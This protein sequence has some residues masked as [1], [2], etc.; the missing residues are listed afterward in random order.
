MQLGVPGDHYIVKTRA[1]WK[2]HYNEFTAT[3]ISTE[4]KGF[5]WLNLPHFRQWVGWWEKKGVLE[6]PTHL[7]GGICST[8]TLEVCGAASRPLSSHPYHFLGLSYGVNPG[9]ESQCCGWLLTHVSSWQINVEL[10]LDAEVWAV[11]SHVWALK[12]PYLVISLA[13]LGCGLCWDK[14]KLTRIEG[15]NL[16]QAQVTNGSTAVRIFHREFLTV[17]KGLD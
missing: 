3:S 14:I 17:F 13:F 1:T 12:Q 16:F 6:R 8:P 10:S 11:E 7:E 9:P 15:K 5:L 4:M 2:R